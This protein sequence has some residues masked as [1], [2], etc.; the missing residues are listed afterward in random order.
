MKRILVCYAT[1]YGST[2]GI[3]TIIADELRDAG[4]EVTLSPASDAGDPAGYDAV[5]IGSP[6]YM[7]KWLADAREFVS[8]FRDS[9]RSRPVAV[10]SA[11]FTLREQTAGN[12]DAADGALASSVRPYLSPVSAGYFAGRLDPDHMTAADR[13]VIALAGTVPGDFRDPG[14]VK[15]WAGTLPSLLFR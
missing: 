4:Y 10:F 11:G 7:G 5:I 2:R 6:L 12:L 15:K 1:R 9:L 14:E 8:R 13:A 3:A